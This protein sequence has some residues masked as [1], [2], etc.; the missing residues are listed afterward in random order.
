[1]KL[2]QAYPYYIPVRAAAEY[3]HIKPEALRA[4]MDQGK[5]PFGFSWA[6]GNRRGYKIPTLAFETWMK[7]GA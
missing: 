5:C 2:I 6:L 3:L 1:M 4:S 7:K